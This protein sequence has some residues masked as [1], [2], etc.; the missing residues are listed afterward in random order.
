MATKDYSNKY[1][2]EGLWRKIRKYARVIGEPLLE[3]VLTLYY[4]MLD[5][6][7]P[8]LAKGVIVAALGY[9][10]FPL[11]AIPDFIPG[12]GYADDLGAI[13]VALG[14]V[15]VHIKPEHRRMA[16]EKVKQWFGGKGG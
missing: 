12:V 13:A 14:M 4:C 6:D 2:E 1:S 3:Q 5:R 15:Y 16:K 7:T 10:I 9:L 8:K 11:D